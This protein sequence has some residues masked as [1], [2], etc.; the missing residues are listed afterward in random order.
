MFTFAPLR[1]REHEENYLKLCHIV[2]LWLA[3]HDCSS[4]EKD[5]ANDTESSMTSVWV[6]EWL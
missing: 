5:W 3:L 1:C 6:T 4:S 2:K